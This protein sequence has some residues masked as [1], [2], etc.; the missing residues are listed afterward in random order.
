L[1][2]SALQAF[3]TSPRACT[4][5]EPTINTHSDMRFFPTGDCKIGKAIRE[6]S[7]APQDQPS[8]L[9]VVSVSRTDEFDQQEAAI[10]IALHVF[11]S[12]ISNL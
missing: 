1:S 11:Y 6:E 7:F 9:L 3:L 12:R 8:P 10:V 2:Q 4:L 5:L